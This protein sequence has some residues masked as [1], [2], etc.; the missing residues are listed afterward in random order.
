MQTPTNPRTVTKSKDRKRTYFLKELLN[1]DGVPGTGLDKN[2]CDGL[3]KLLGFLHRNLPVVEM[4]TAHKRPRGLHTN[5]KTVWLR[6]KKVLCLELMSASVW[7]NKRNPEERTERPDWK[8]Q[9]RWRTGN[10]R[11]RLSSTFWETKILHLKSWWKKGVV[12]RSSRLLHASAS[13][14]QGDG[15]TC[16]Y[17]SSSRTTNS[18]GSDGFGAMTEWGDS[19]D[20]S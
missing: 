19:P 12:I 20:V 8:R 3:G 10:K 18:D 9:T 2:S 15:I 13:G 14:N 4:D 11:D 5:Y 1:I 6:E 7:S 17:V 16:P